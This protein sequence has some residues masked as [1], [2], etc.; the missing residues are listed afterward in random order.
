MTQPLQVYQF[1]RD[2]A[3]A[4]FLQFIPIVTTVPTPYSIE[5]E[6]YGD[7]L[8]SIFDEWVR[9]DVGRIFVQLFDLALAA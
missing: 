5:A 7:F 9:H 2:E 4:Q 6:R 3:G 8:C 1:F